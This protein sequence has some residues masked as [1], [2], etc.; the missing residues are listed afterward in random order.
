MK[1]VI[2]DDEVILANSLGAKLESH[3]FEVSVFYS[4]EE[5][6]TKISE[7]CDIYIFDISIGEAS[8]FDVL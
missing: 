7:P 6:E 3:G 2:L 8:G 4:Y 5:F 1:A